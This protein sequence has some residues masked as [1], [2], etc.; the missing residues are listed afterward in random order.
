MHLKNVFPKN[1]CNALTLVISFY[2]KKLETSD[3]AVFEKIV[4]RSKYTQAHNNSQQHN[5]NLAV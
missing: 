4:S 2:E 1:F 3:I 5:S